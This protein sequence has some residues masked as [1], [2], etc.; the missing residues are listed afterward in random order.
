V[1]Q[2]IYKREKGTCCVAV[3]RKMSDADSGAEIRLGIKST[4]AEIFCQ[5]GK[6]KVR[7]A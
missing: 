3:A 1:L 5:G 7:D 2:I 6:I 4:S